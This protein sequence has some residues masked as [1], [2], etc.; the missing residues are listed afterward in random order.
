MEEKSLSLLFFW[1]HR[2]ELVQFSPQKVNTGLC[3]LDVGFYSK[4][5]LRVTQ[6][7]VNVFFLAFTQFCHYSHIVST[8]TFCITKTSSSDISSLRICNLIICVLC[9]PSYYSISLHHDR[10]FNHFGK[11]FGCL[12]LRPA[13]PSSHKKIVL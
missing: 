11:S 8:H 1:S 13:Y 3:F 4:R 9:L 5:S 2:K 12:D 7:Q 10:L 6:Q